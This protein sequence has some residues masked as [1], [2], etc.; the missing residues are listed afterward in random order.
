MSASVSRPWRASH[1]SWNLS[2]GT[3][4][5]LANVRM[6]LMFEPGFKLWTNQIAWLLHCVGAWSDSIWHFPH[7]NLASQR[8]FLCKRRYA[9]W[10][11][12]C[13]DEACAS[14]DRPMV[15]VMK[16]WFKCCI[17]NGFRRPGLCRSRSKSWCAQL[18]SSYA[19]A[20]IVQIKDHQL[21][22]NS[23]GTL[24]SRT[25]EAEWTR[26][27]WGNSSIWSAVVH[28]ASHLVQ[29]ECQTRTALQ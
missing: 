24:I 4:M 16:S 10:F 23:S 11:D 27:R 22:A 26:L 28:R 29:I 7:T 8:A 3:S 6:K 18:C 1:A 15:S 13:L 25:F 14:F 20:L 5:S 17:T 2:S 12:R 21:G 9:C 19:A